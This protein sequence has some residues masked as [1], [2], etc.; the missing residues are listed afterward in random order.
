MWMLHNDKGGKELL[1]TFRIVQSGRRCTGEYVIA[2]FN[3]ED[4]QYSV[5]VENGE[6][7]YA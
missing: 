4:T 7:T 5:C 3:E 2:V 1:F 6:Q